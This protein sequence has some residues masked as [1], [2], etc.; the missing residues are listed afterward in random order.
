MDIIV[1]Q[2]FYCT[3]WFDPLALASGKLLNLSKVLRK[4]MVGL[5]YNVFRKGRQ[6]IDEQ[7]E[8][9]EGCHAGSS[10]F[11]FFLIPFIPN[12]ISDVK[13]SWNPKGT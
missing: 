9:L 5:A 2:L 6:H 8:H 7:K 3:L 12:V 10:V 13:E 4:S 1:L 11:L